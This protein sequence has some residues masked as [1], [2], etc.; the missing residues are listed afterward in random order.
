MTESIFS[1][2]VSTRWVKRHITETVSV[3]APTYLAEAERQE[4]LAVGSLERP[5]AVASA[6]DLDNWP[7]LQTPAI[8]CV[9]PGVLGDPERHAQGRYSAWFGF[10]LGVYV[11][12]QEEAPALECA[13]TY[14]AAIEDLIIQQGALG[15]QGR[16]ETLWTSR[17]LRL[18]DPTN[19]T[20]VCAVSAFKVIVDSV[21]TAG[22]GP[23]APEP[24]EK[25]G[26][27]G[28][29]EPGNE[30]EYPPWPLVETTHITVTGESIA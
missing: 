26:A 24:V 19:R 11:E 10:Q 16:Q 18:P 4:G 3:W 6:F 14:Q 27:P 8:F 23:V 25:P 21:I 22:A 7:E 5:R 9:C 28:S 1:P 29:S 13:E 12:E 15:D 20:Q 17:S 30:A 2:I